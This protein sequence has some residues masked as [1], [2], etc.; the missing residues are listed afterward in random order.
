M[1]GSSSTSTADV[2]P[3]GTVTVSLD[4]VIEPVGSAAPSWPVS[5]SASVTG[6]V[7]VL[8]YVSEVLVGWRSE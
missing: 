2:P 5:A 7:P 8:V 4:S 6:A 1:V 3:P